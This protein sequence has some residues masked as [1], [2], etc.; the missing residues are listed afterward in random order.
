MPSVESA[1]VGTQSWNVALTSQVLD[2]RVEGHVAPLQ[3]V[4]CALQLLHRRHQCA[5]HGA[6]G[7]KRRI[8]A[9]EVIADEALDVALVI[10]V[11]ELLPGREIEP[12]LIEPAAEPLAVLGDEARHEA[13]GDHGAHQQQS[14][15]QSADK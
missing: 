2:A 4:H 14:V 6:F 1:K 10:L 8:A 13:A 7:V 9:L 3:R 15:E 5:D 12:C 11:G